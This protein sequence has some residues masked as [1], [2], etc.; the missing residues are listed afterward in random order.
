M[1]LV[2]NIGNSN[3]RLGIFKD[4]ECV[5]SWVMNTKPYKTEDELFSQFKMTYRNY[6]INPADIEEI[7][8]GSVVP[9]LTYPVR[10]SLARLHGVKT[11][12]V[13]RNTDT[14]LTSASPQM[15]TDLYANAYYAH[16]KYCGNKIIV[17]FGTALTLTCVDKNGEIKGVIIAAGVVTSLNSLIGATAQLSDVEMRTPKRVLGK[18]TEECMQ[19]GIVF[20]FLSMVEGLI[21]RINKE[22]GEETYVVATGGIGHLFAPLT[23]KIDIY[24]RFHTIKGLRELYL[25]LNKQQD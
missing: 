18:T 24:D 8:V 13:S 10:K 19:S 22:L 16:K 1:L 6:G 11:I 23:T 12:L 9:H 15:G 17:D 21:D 25:R 5:N 3:I 4:D 2:V 14:E 7:A 20:G